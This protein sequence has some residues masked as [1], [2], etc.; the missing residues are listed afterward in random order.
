MWRGAGC[1]RCA[2]LG[3]GVGAKHAGEFLGAHGIDL[4]GLAGIAAGAL[5]L[6]RKLL[7]GLLLLW[8]GWVGWG[9]GHGSGGW[10]NSFW[11]SYR[12]C[13]WSNPRGSG[14]SS[15]CGCRDIGAGVFTKRL[16]QL[17]HT[18]LVHILGLLGVATNGLQL[19]RKLLAGLAFLIAADQ[20]AGL[21]LGDS[22]G[23]G[24]NQG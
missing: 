12:G 17:Q 23:A 4:L 15:S 11:S 13:H 18:L 19:A 10:D 24:E 1:S 22:Q 8:V 6:G 3:A 14:G 7:A 5:E 16:H 20:G 9:S 21:G 2:H